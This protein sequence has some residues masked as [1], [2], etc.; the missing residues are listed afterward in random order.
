M[1]T[2]IEGHSLIVTSVAIT[3]D[4]N[5][6]VSGSGDNTIKVWDMNTVGLLSALEGHT[7][8]VTSIATTTENSKIVSG[9]YDNTIKIWDLRQGKCFLTYRFDLPIP[10][11]ALSKSR[12]FMALGDSSGNL[13]SGMLLE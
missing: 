7:S 1:K 3:S 8:R 9:S 4:N 11:I 2:T 12:N 6:I 5:K 13:Y 10:S